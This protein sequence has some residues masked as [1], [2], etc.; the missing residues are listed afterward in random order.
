ML[1]LAG[2][3]AGVD[4]RARVPRT[5]DLQHPRRALRHPP[6]HHGQTPVPPPLPHSTR[7]LL[8]TACRATQLAWHG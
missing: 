4:Q 2:D 3:P 7:P 6:L 8:A 1:R 5:L